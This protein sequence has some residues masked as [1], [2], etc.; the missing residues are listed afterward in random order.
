MHDRTGRDISAPG[1]ESLIIAASDP[2]T[3]HT[4][5]HFFGYVLIVLVDAGGGVDAGDAGPR[6]G[7]VAVRVGGVVAGVSVVSRELAPWSRWGR[8]GS[9]LA[10]VHPFAT[11]NRWRGAVSAS[12]GGLNQVSG[13][14]TGC[15]GHLRP[16]RA[17]C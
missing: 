1:L 11:S 15:G 9:N 2:N 12:A 16:E 17:P 4:E 8:A 10:A 7:V 6:A 3:T 13:R 5:G 14:A